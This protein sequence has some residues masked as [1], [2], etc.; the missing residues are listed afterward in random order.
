[1]DKSERAACAAARRED[2]L[3]VLAVRARSAWWPKWGLRSVKQRLC[4]QLD[5]YNELNPLQSRLWFEVLRDT[6]CDE[7]LAQAVDAHREGRAR[8][9]ERERDRAV[10]ELERERRRMR[11][12]SPRDRIREVG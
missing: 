3:D 4:H 6:G 2:R 7:M 10:D 9:A 12:V 11:T 5:P 8:S 1:M